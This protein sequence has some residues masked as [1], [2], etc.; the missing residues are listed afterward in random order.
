MEAN[1]CR[2]ALESLKQKILFTRLEKIYN[3][4]PKLWTFKFS[5][6][7][8]LCLYAS[9]K[10]G[11]FFL[12]PNNLDNPSSPSP[13]VMFLRK[14]CKNR[15]VKSF[16]FFWPRRIFWLGFGDLFLELSLESEPKIVEKPIL[17]EV[18]WPSLEEID[19][20]KEIFRIYPQISP[21][22]RKFLASLSK[23]R[24]KNFYLKLQV[25][26][27]FDFYIYENNI[28][29]WEQGSNVI[30]KTDNPLE[31]LSIFGEYKLKE[32]IGERFSKLKQQ[33]REEKRLKKILLKLEE[34]KKKLKKRIELLE[35]GKLLQANLYNL[36]RNK[37][38]SKVNV[39]DF[40]G[41]TITIFLD[42]KKT[43]LENMENFFK[44]A[45]KGERGLKAIEKRKQQIQ[46][47]LQDVRIK[48]KQEIKIKQKAFFVPKKYQG[49]QIKAFI[50]SDGFLILRGK[51]SKA[52]HKLLSVASPFDLWFHAQDGPGAHV[53]LRRDSKKQEVPLQ[54]LKEAA[55]LAA[56]AS[57]QKNA[58][59]GKVMCAEVKNV[60][61]V[62]G[63]S[64]GQ[65]I[66][67]KILHSF[68]IDIDPNLET[69]LR[70]LE[71]KE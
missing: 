10:G 45:A 38:V 53:I 50:S 3:P 2:F 51:N 60:R 9:Q 52:N 8:F 56:L 67:D 36:D 23:E 37:K 24:K 20:N 43:I 34:D 62:K 35:Y 19:S 1:F 47:Q 54:S 33:N 68:W 18:I 48:Q 6:Q 59:K 44:Q 5:K 15:I 69:K 71:T 65:V 13:K 4:Y 58:E 12:R 42:C 66:V 27:S 41:N 63:L 39:I 29:L 7:G 14:H 32:I 70:Y 40:T 31:A 11:F 17:E 25:E 57:Y 46:K 28:L 64:L 49:L 16:S 61:K 22:L 26:K 55:C 21:P 30:S